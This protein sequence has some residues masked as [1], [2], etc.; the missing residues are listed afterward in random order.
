MPTVAGKL[1]DMFNLF[2]PMWMAALA[3]IFIAFISLFYIET[4]PGQV[5][6]MKNK[7][8]REDHLFKVFR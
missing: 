7:P 8:T 3:G 2:A 4:A 1:A 6:K 5:A